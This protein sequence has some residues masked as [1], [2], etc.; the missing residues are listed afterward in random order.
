MCHQVLRSPSAGGSSPQ[1]I[2]VDRAADTPGLHNRPPT[3]VVQ[4]REEDVDRV[5]REEAKG[6]RGSVDRSIQVMDGHIAVGT[7][8]W[9]E[10]RA[11]PAATVQVYGTEVPSYD[12]FDM[13]GICWNSLLSVCC[14]AKTKNR[15]RGRALTPPALSAASPSRSRRKICIA[16][17]KL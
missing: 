7:V 5:R 13:L 9:K 15:P 10:C 12:W 6:E 11:K 14:R 4:S 1:I 3:S 17:Q 2:R 16:Q 8:Q